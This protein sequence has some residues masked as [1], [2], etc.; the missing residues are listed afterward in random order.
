[1]TI[2][3]KTAYEVEMQYTPDIL[4]RS[5]VRKKSGIRANPDKQEGLFLKHKM[6]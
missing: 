6:K 1:M 5:E 4:D 3:W 2:S